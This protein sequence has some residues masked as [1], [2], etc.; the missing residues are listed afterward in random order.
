MSG[1][2]SSGELRRRP[3]DGR[4]GPHVFVVD[5]EDPELTVEDRHHLATV[6]RLGDG[7][8]MPIPDGLARGQPCRCRATIQ[9]CGD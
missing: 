9:P 5:L 1:F 2:G 7:A 6:L 8:E 3:P 4:G